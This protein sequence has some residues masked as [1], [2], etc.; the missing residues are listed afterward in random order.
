MLSLP[1]DFVGT[2]LLQY[3][4]AAKVGSWHVESY[5][6]ELTLVRMEGSAELEQCD[7][8]FGE[9]MVSEPPPPSRRQIGFY[10]TFE[11]KNWKL[12]AEKKWREK[13]VD[14]AGFEHVGDTKIKG[15]PYKVMKGPESFAAVPELVQN[16][17]KD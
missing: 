15:K 12:A 8:L 11:G 10:L 2:V 6:K 9:V 16:P 14:I 7:Y 17:E 5:G 13:Q 1:V 4:D 3:K